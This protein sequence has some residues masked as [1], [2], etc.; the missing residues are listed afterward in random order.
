MSSP[1]AERPA[2]ERLFF[3]LWPCDEV[4]QQLRRHA[5]ELLRHS[6][7][8]P[9]TPE[10]LH[11]TLAFLGSV[12]AVQRQCVE[13]VAASIVLS[14]FTLVLDQVGYWSRPRVL[15]L[16]AHDT[17]ATPIELAN[18]LSRGCRDCGL[19]LDRRPF[20]AHL[21]LKRKVN[22]APPALELKPVSW[23]VERFALVRSDT[24]PEGVRYTVVREWG[25]TARTED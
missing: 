8:R 14:P 7:G 10:N 6:G 9:V 20:K 2:V 17:P 21:T 1:P 3:A 25:L 16:G 11:I 13:Q 12:D 5:K 15:W 18:Q 23:P 4:R 22:Q 19:S 24:R